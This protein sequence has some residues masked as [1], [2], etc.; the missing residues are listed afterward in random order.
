MVADTDAVGYTEGTDGS[1]TTFA[2]G[3]AVYELGQDL[4]PSCA[5]APPSCGKSSLTR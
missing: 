1:R 2:T 4:R 5:S 3:W